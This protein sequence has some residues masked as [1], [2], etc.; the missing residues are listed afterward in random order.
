MLLIAESNLKL[1]I[2]SL[3]L[4]KLNHEV[5]GLEALTLLFTII[6]FVILLKDSHLRY[7]NY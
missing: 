6:K 4:L 7:E 5:D 1:P 3:S 2:L